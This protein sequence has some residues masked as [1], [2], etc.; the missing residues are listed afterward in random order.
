MSDYGKSKSG[1]DYRKIGPRCRR[2]AGRLRENMALLT[3]GVQWYRTGQKTQQYGETSTDSK[4][5]GKQRK[6]ETSGQ[7]GK[8]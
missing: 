8:S 1:M 6:V 2:A 4:I 7:A 5:P 3:M